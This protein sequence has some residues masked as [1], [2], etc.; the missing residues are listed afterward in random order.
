MFYLSHHS[1]F[2]TSSNSSFCLIM[3]S[4]I[5]LACRYLVC[6][7]MLKPHLLWVLD[8]CICRHRLRLLN[9]AVRCSSSH[10]LPNATFFFPEF[11]K[12][13]VNVSSFLWMAYFR[14]WISGSILVCFLTGYI[15]PRRSMMAFFCALASAVFSPFQLR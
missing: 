7:L 15:T 11:F 2:K 8:R 5:T 6:C 13:I 1:L 10:S 9:C 14:Q 3:R 12:F 4:P